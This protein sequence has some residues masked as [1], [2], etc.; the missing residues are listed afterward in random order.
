M[1]GEALQWDYNKTVFDIEAMQA[2]EVL[3]K[4]KGLSMPF[5]CQKPWKRV[6]SQDAFT[7]AG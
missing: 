6:S 4:G 2:I 1:G 3:D 7:A 5:S